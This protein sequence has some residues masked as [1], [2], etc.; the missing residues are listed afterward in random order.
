MASV[1]VRRSVL[2]RA[3]VTDKLRQEVSAELQEAADDI[4]RRLEELDTAG[5]RYIT[6]LQRTDLQRAMA[7]RTQ[8]ETEKRR[9]QEV[10][11]Q[12]LQR[13]EAVG[14]WENGTEV[15]RG[16]IE[17]YV[18]V[19]EGDNLAVLLGGTEIV[20]EDDIVKA[21]RQLSPDEL[22]VRLRDAIAA[23]EAGEETGEDVIG[24][25]QTP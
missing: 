1:I 20:V 25:I 24:R 12:L 21:I 9:Q 2:L 11:E 6:D 15:V 18:E 23:G 14:K 17:G 16:T 4:A 13:R 5:R 8:V 10:R 22:S 3:I 19:N 7:L